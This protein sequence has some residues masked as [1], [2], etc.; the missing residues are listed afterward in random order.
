MSD[1]LWWIF[2]LKNLVPASR[3]FCLL[4][5]LFP[6]FFLFGGDVQTAASAVETDK[7]KRKIRM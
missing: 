2:L 3:R 1:D 4:V 6:C 5:F 7:N